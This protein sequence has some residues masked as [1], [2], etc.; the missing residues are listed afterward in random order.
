MAGGT[1]TTQNK[2]RPGAYVN[3]KSTGN[4]NTSESTNGVMTLPLVLDF[5]PEGVVTEITASSD[6]TQFGYDLASEKLL[7]LQEALKQAAKVL[8]YRVGSGAK[9]TITEGPL[10][11]TA[12]FGGTRGNDINVVS[13]ANVNATG[14]FDVETFVA[15]RSVDLQ[16]VKTCEEL[17]AN[18]VVTF[19]GEGDLT[20][21]SVTL[22][23]GTNTAATV[24]DYMTYFSKI[25]V[26]DFNT[27]ALPVSD[28]AIK[29]A[30]A[31]F[32]KRMRDEEGKKSQLVL[33]GY[34]A[35]HEAVINV[36]NGVILANG[37]QLSAEQATAW[38][39]GA[40][41]SAGVATSLTYK[42]YDG[43][44]DVT[45]RFLNSE[46]IEALQKGEF[47]FTEKR[48][49]AVIEQDINSL[50][51]FTS[52]K[53]QDF[54][55]NRVLRVLDDIANNTKKTFEDN[56]IGKVNNDQDG[57]EMFKAN[58][59][60]YF[61][62]LQAAGAITNFAADDVEVVAGEAK[63]SIVMNV[64]VQPVDAMEKLYMTVQVV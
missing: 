38:V 53:G 58:R 12:L 20:A 5:G 33:A 60:T 30:G 37:T 48:G 27:M 9:A 42:K 25:Q 3:V 6:L 19:A 63:D 23:G 1:W 4:V 59:I 28:E 61:D 29:T 54:S 41:A 45:Q 16:T 43:A 35:D 11:V 21:F 44:V 2:M 40:A 52:D 7:L 31:A 39:A 49:E 62:S 18:R 15:G 64:A 55:K 46:I 34:N 13:K 26:F 50:H 10:T 57:R 32:I 17:K 8:L 47:L 51:T 14:S 56:F 36:K 22:E 24:N